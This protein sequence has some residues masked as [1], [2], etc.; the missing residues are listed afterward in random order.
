MKKILFILLLVVS[1]FAV[2]A[3][4]NNCGCCPTYAPISNQKVICTSQYNPCC[5]LDYFAPIDP[6]I[7]YY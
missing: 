1:S 3:P 4:T 7:D 5:R 6:Y 2:T